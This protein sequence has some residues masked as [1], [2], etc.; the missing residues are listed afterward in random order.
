M[1]Q[2]TIV[3]SEAAFGASGRK[4][5]RIIKQ[6]FATPR[7]ECHTHVLGTERLATNMRIFSVFCLSLACPDG[8]FRGALG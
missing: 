6:H 7:N 8:S 1:S 5:I 3:A 2:S 4:A